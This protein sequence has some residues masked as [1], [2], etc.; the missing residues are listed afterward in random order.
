M[1]VYYSRPQETMVPFSGAGSQ[2]RPAIAPLADGGYVIVWQGPEDNGTTGVFGRRFDASGQP[3]SDGFHVNTYTPNMQAFADVAGLSDGGFVVTWSSEGQNGTDG[4]VFGQRYNAA[5]APVGSEFQVGSGPSFYQTTARVAGLEDGRFVVVWYRPGDSAP[6]AFGQIYAADGAPIGDRFDISGG[7]SGGQFLPDVA[8]LDDGGFV[9]SWTSAAAPGDN[10]FDI[11]AR[12][13]D[14]TGAGSDVFRVNTITQGEQNS[15]SITALEGGGFVVLWKNEVYGSRIQAY[16]SN[17]VPIGGEI[18]FAYASG[19]Q[20]V[21]GLPDGGFLV[22][23][24]NI[25]GDTA[26]VAVRRY[27]SGAALV[28]EESIVNVQRPD[29]Q[30][31]PSL[32]TLADGSVVVTWVSDGQDGDGYGIFSR[33]YRLSEEGLLSEQTDVAMGTN[34]SD[35]MW[36]FAGDDELHGYSGDDIFEGGIGAD[37]I[38]GDGGWDEVTY[39]GATASVSLNLQTG[40]HTGEAAGDTF[41]SIEQFSLTRF[42]D[43]FIGT[44]AA[45]AVYGSAG[46]DQLIG[47]GGNDLL[48]GGNG[49]DVLEGGSGADT[50]D[51]DTGEDEV[52]YFRAS[53][54]VGVDLVSAGGSGDAA[55]DTF[56]S[57]E[58]FTLSRFNDVFIGSAA[59]DIVFGGNGNDMLNGGGGADRMNGGNGNDTYIVDDAGDSVRETS[60]TGGTDVVQSSVTFSLANQYVETLVLT[61]TANINGHGNSLAN[62]L[63]GNAAAN[64]LNGQEGADSMAGGLGND[65]FI[66]DNAGDLA[67]EANGGG[68]DTVQASV[69]FTLAGQYIENLTLT[70]SG[71]INGTGNSLANTITGNGAA[72][73]LSGGEGDDTLNGA[74][75]ADTMSGG[76]GSDTFLVD[77]VGDTVSE[78]NVAGTD[79]V[80][81]TVTFNL[82]GQ[83]IENLVLTGTAAINGTGNS[84]ANSITG[85]SAANALSGGEG[86]DKLYGKAGSDTLNGGIGI[87]DFHFDTA[88]GV[89]NVDTI[90]SYSVADDTI[91]L[92][93]AIFTG[94]TANGALAASAFVTGTAA[95]DGDDRILYDSATGKIFYDADGNGAGAAVL[96]AQVAAGTALT[97]LDF[98]AYLPA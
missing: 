60:W 85:N 68:T 75:G 87:D 62:T 40:S 32:A 67:I 24:A 66:V 63:T 76:L 41:Q 91:K 77:N 7:M 33:R 26:D 42:A 17:A 49:D 13:F 71:A 56:H 31:Q 37:K 93:R 97:N 8:A 86:A 61:G 3:T 53:A 30:F 9:I 38:F 29:G 6:D 27:D 92:D 96:F 89:T 11:R 21:T 79:T 2:E 95:G 14:S 5:G 52:S 78:S 83:Y 22:A 35:Y 34:G 23:Y 69:T 28:G 70:G 74:G 59:T 54:A 48:D 25:A 1:P 16:D 73:S 65:T 45:E 88:L 12:R 50:M 4:S 84:L 47:S 55:G 20:S 98:V 39:D 57:I 82:A 94:I 15:S 10:G 90:Q 36:G 46:D 80:Q 51:G 43:R 81:S 58:K 18:S 19:L 64:V 44:S 72:N